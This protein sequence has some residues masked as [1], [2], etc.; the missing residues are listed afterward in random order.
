M[1]GTKSASSRTSPVA[2]CKLASWHNKIRQQFDRPAS[3]ELNFATCRET[4]ACQVCILILLDARYV[5]LSRAGSG[6]M[7]RSRRPGPLGYEHEPVLS[8]KHV[9]ASQTL[10]SDFCCQMQ[11][12]FDVIVA[13]DGLRSDVRSYCQ[14]ICREGTEGRA[15]RRPNPKCCLRVSRGEGRLQNLILGGSVLLVGDARRVFRHEQPALH[16]QSMPWTSK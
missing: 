16:S 4:I 10:P 6:E 7:L 13:A 2:C 15:V 14:A 5:A 12:P 11:G 3:A 8:A 9:A 1:A